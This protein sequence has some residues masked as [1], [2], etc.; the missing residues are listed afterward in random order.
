MLTGDAPGHSTAGF[1]EIALVVGVNTESGALGEERT[2]RSLDELT[3]LAEACGAA[4][5]GR[6]VQNRTSPDTATYIGS[7]K[8]AE[9]ADEAKEMGANTLIFDDELSG[10]QM[11][12]IQEQIKLRVLDRT[13]VI[14]DIFARRASSKEGKL[15]VELA[16][17]EYRLSRTSLIN[18]E[19]SRLAG[20][21]G[22]RGPGESQLEIDRRHIRERITFLKRSLK[23][24]GKRRRRVQEK[25]EDNGEILV[26]AVGYT[27]AGKSSLINRL[28]ESDLLV[29]DQV[30]ATLDSA[31]RNM[32]LPG[33][34][35]IRLVDTVGFIRKLP[36]Q[37]VE[38]FQSTLEIT[39][40]ADVILHVTDVSDP[41]YEQH[42]Q[43]VD[44]ELMRLGVSTKPQ[45]HVLNK[46]D[47][48]DEQLSPELLNNSSH[49]AMYRTVP[50]SV[51]NNIGIEEL[52]E[53]IEQLIMLQQKHYKLELPYTES[54]LHAYIKQ[55]GTRLKEEFKDTFM[56]LDFY[57]D[58]RQI[59]P[60]ERYIED[61]KKLQSI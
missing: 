36:H 3:E 2:E 34:N 51:L 58:E 37:L 10:S 6:A 14:L 20:G 44:S 61:E 55:R 50:V 24:V 22:T 15:Q 52:T 13:L 41:D 33:G 11:R 28:S 46:I 18:E 60:V 8:L 5:I 40:D 42:I 49:N 32:R 47:L 30:F 12:N 4:V 48:L 7:G 21:I 45:I 54:R 43:V 23:E 39:R 35:D 9:I 19:L 56:A 25:R 16:Q 1:S 31:V 29:M 59:G 53:N 26:V 17:Y 38:S 27:N 57:M